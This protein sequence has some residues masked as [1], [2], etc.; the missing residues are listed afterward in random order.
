MLGDFG[1]GALRVQAIGIET[2]SK[3]MDRGQ[4]AGAA[5]SPL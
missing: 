2:A 3:V 1:S 5:D 4:G